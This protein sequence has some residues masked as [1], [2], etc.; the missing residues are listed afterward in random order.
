MASIP[1]RYRSSTST[2]NPA[3][4]K[5]FEILKGLLDGLTIDVNHHQE[6]GYP[7][8]SSLSKKLRHI[9]QHIA[10][11][12]TPVH[13]DDFRHAKGFELILDLLRAFSGY[14]N[15]D[16]RNDADMLSLFKMLGEALGVLS[17]ALRDHVGNTR[18]FRFKVEGG[19]W[20]AL[21]QVIASIGLGGAEPDAW[22]SCHVFGKLLSFILDDDALDLLCQTVAKSL[23]P[24]DDQTQDDDNE[25]QW[26][27]VLAKSAENI[28]PGVR[29]VVNTR[30][31][32]RYPEILRAVVSFWTAIPRIKNGIASPGSLL[33]LEAIHCIISISI[34][35]RAAVHGTGVLSQFLRVVFDLNS[36]LSSVEREKVLGICRMLMFLGVNE[37]SDT[38]FLLSAGG[39]EAAEFCLQMTSRYFGP[40]FFQFDLS[41]HGHSSLE[42]SNLGRSFPPQSSAGYTFSAWIRVDSF[43]PTAHTTIFG[44]Y[45]SSQACF[46]LMYLERDTHNFILQTSVFSNK[47]SVRFKSVAFRE[48]KWYHIAIVHRRPKT[49]TTSKA[50]LYVNGE[51]AEQIRCNYPHQPPLSNGP[52]ESFASFNSN[53]NKTNPVQAFLGTPRQLSS[54][55]GPGLVFSRWS[56][57]SA[58]LFEDALSDDFL[59]VHYGLG[60][61]YQGNFQDSLGGFQTYEA[62]ATLGLRNEIAHS[63]KGENSDIIKA[64]REKASLLLPE[65]KVLMSILPSATFPE[66]VQFLDTGLLRSLPRNCARNLFKVSNQ[67]GAPLAINCAVPSLPD[68]LFRVQGLASFRGT[69]IVAVPSYLD[70]NLWSLAGFTPLALKLFERA[71][72]VEETVRAAEMLFHCIRQNWRNSEAMERDNGYG[73]LGMLLRVKLGYGGSSNVTASRLPITSEERDRLAFQL[74]SLSLGFVGYNHAEPLESFIINPLAYRILLIDLDIWRKSAPRIQE[75]YYKQFVTF[76]VKSKHHEFNSRRLIRMRKTLP[77]ANLHC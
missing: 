64:V 36:A 37:P 69:P 72:T 39:S 58:H 16:K 28:A 6:N 15:P 49:M 14:Y 68:S 73:I 13:K 26:D 62:S 10:A 77:L 23:R 18:F 63:G 76:A 59:A 53:Q 60:P 29:E 71:S 2:S 54:Q 20:E 50:S 17:A 48:K 5:S 47:P 38:Q 46:L 11:S 65:S 35:N 43:D 66:N 52:S 74:L 9:A 3:S 75:L 57:A 27:L 56:L 31:I 32:I 44:V 51:F 40:P 42:L 22:I 1:R 45:D 30:T 61:R 12:V 33:V 70:E 8:I 24:E 21:E 7:D 67:E 19:G 34:F 25:E 4:S 55:L 41:L